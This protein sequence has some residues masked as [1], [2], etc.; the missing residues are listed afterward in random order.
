M[1]PAVKAVADKGRDTTVILSG[2]TCVPNFLHIT[3]E[4]TH[5]ETVIKCANFW[6]IKKI[7][8]KA[9][10]ATCLPTVFSNVKH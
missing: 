6:I 10:L 4:Q 2:Q 7:C 8:K 1:A 9:L 3:C 5:W